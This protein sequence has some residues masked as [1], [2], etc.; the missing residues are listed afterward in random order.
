MFNYQIRSL[1]SVCESGGEFWGRS[2]LSAN[3]SEFTP[4]FTNVSWMRPI[5][6]TAHAIYSYSEI[7]YSQCMPGNYT[8]FFSLRMAVKNFIKMGQVCHIW[9][10]NKMFKGHS[11]N[12]TQEKMEP[13]RT[14]RLAIAASSQ[15]LL[16]YGEPCFRFTEVLSEYFWHLLWRVR[17]LRG[18]YCITSTLNI[19]YCGL[20]ALDLYPMWSVR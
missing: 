15:T 9:W 20:G 19:S 6:F 8:F 14:L 1:W 17:L 2:V 12:H 5:V 18:L 13:D 11:T 7:W 10:C 16:S 3:Y 4:I